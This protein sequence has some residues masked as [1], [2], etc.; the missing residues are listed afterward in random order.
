MA[1]EPMCLGTD[2]IENVETPLKLITMDHLQRRHVP[3]LLFDYKNRVA[4]VQS[5]VDQMWFRISTRIGSNS[6]S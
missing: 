2:Q 6:R 4:P 1:S 3:A 5:T